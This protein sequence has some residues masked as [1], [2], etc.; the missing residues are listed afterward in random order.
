[1]GKVKPI[2]I[3]LKQKTVS[4]SGIS[5]AICKSAPRT[6]QITMPEPCHGFLQAR[7]PSC[8]PTNSLKALKALCVTVTVSQPFVWDYPGEPVPEETF[9]NSHLSW[10]STTLYQ[11]PLSTMIHS[12]LPVQFTCL[13]VFLNNLSP[14]PLSCIPCSTSCSIHFFTQSLSSFC[15]T[16]PWLVTIANKSSQSHLGRAHL[17]HTIM[18]QGAH[19]IQWDAPNSPPKLLLP[20]HWSP[21]P[22]NTPIPQL[23]PFTILNGIKIQSAILTQYTFP[24][25]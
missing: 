10:S 20:L 8:H 25:Q 17:S 23:T 9:T 11:F 21:P 14:G 7:C 15:N 5:W 2:W 3:L 13:T 6:R 19:W 16:C 12:I 18:Q 22:S 24:D 4:G 1:M